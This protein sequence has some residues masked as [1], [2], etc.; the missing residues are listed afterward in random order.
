M[1]ILFMTSPAPQMAPVSTKEKRPPLGLGFLMAILKKR[2][3]QMHFVDNYL[4][5]S[6]ILETDFLLKKHIDVVGIYANSICYPTTLHLLESL[7]RLRDGGKWNGRIA[8]G[9]P[10]TSVALDTVPEFV[11]TILLGEGEISFPRVIESGD[12]TRVV[13]GEK[14]PDLDSLP[15]PAWEEFIFHRYQWK[16]SWV[17]EYPVYTFN[18]SRGC[19]YACTFCSVNGV[20]GRSYRVMSAERILDDIEYMIRHYG[21]RVAY[22]REDHF[23]L[24]KRRTIE[25]CEGLLRRRINIRWMCETRADSIADPDIMDLMARSGCACLYIGVE[26][27]SPRMLELFDKKETVE[28]FTDVF[29]LART[30]GIR[31]YASFVVGAPTETDEDMRKT[32]ELI[33]RIRPDF[34]YMN[35]FIGLPGSQLYEYVREHNLYEYETAGRV[36]YLKGHDKRV[37]EFCGGDPR[38]KIPPTNLARQVFNRVRYQWAKVSRQSGNNGHELLERLA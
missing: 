16:H 3:H 17:P 24:N 19:P 34:L 15:R 10:H 23:T 27:G 22:F 13:T 28:Q 11:D 18:T 8:I 6:N 14:V 32:H 5:P 37:D 26:S 30:S 38:L 1:N 21:L 2:G 35:I 33:R 29:D 25:F 9:G 4:R 36:L 31:T 7:Q 20:W 12:T